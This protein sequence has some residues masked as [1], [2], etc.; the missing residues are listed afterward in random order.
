MKRELGSLERALVTLDR[1]AP[2]HS[3][4]VLRIEAP[5]PSQYLGRALKFLQ[6]RHPFLRTCLL[7]ENGRTFFSELVEPVVPFRVL[8]RW[9]NDHWVKVAEVELDARIE[10]NTSPMFRCTYLYSENQRYA[11]IILTF[12]HSIVDT[13]SVGFLMDELL[14]ACASFMDGEPTAVSGLAPAPALESR[15]PSAYHGIRLSVRAL[16]YNLRQVMD[17]TVYRI[18]TREKRTPPRHTKPSHGH[19]L[20]LTLPES[21]VASLFHRADLEKITLNA[22]LN[23]ALMIAVNRHLYAGKDTP[24][25][26]VSLWDMRPYVE[27][28][29]K[30]ADLGSYISPL[31][32][33]VPVNGGM[34]VWHLAR[35][36][37]QRFFRS[38]KS[39][40]HFAAASAVDSLLRMAV[41]MRSF[42]LGSTVLNFYG[43]LPIKPKYGEFIVHDLHG[44][45]SA[46]RLGPEFFGQVHFFQG[47]LTWDFSYL[48]ADMTSD[49]AKA[50]VEE[51]KSILTSAVTSPLFTI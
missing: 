15:F 23:A 41:R 18:Q 19:I 29:L 48:E 16:G 38:L 13:P 36:L 10:S 11:E 14:T 39:G 8:P 17:E 3:V 40:E 5:P 2:F 45:V 50:I 21:F 24:M 33:T 37:Q 30:N 6:K 12:F 49:E 4:Y 27:P 22:L 43:K 42:R 26:T 44:Y 46:H 1:Y 28:P 9:N 35:S 20:S 25:R 7:Q 31:R 32:H 34:N 47:Q 51:I